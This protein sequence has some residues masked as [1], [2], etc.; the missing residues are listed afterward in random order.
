[1]RLARDGEPNRY[2]DHRPEQRPKRGGDEEEPD[3]RERREAYD[4]DQPRRRQGSDGRADEPGV[5]AR[6]GYPAGQG[7]PAIQTTAERAT[8]APIAPA[9]SP[10]AASTSGAT[11]P[12]TPVTTPRTA[13]A[14]VT[15]AIARS[16]RANA[17][18]SR[19]RPAGPSALTSRSRP[20]FSTSAKRQRQCREGDERKAIAERV[21]GE[22]REHR[23]DE[24]AGTGGGDQPSRAGSA[25]AAG[26]RDRGPDRPQDPEA[27]PEQRSREQQR[28]ETAGESMPEHRDGQQH[29]AGDEQ[30]MGAD[31]TGQQ[32]DRHRRGQHGDRLRGEESPCLRTRET[33]RVAERGKQ[34]YER[35]LPRAGRER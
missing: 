22:A 13:E 34:R 20:T 23:A 3:D 26:G 1:M 32:P 2:V 10:L 29:G 11:S 19:S 7:A 15:P 17:T 8:T 21:G 28:G 12:D 35:G 33:E 25:P 16:R 6:S 27:Q 9:E 30:A 18:A 31:P 14:T 5:D 4:R 24:P